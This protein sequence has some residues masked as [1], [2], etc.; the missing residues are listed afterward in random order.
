MKECYEEYA[1]DEIAE[2]DPAK[3]RTLLDRHDVFF[4]YKGLIAFWHDAAGFILKSAKAAK[5]GKEIFGQ[6][7]EILEIFARMTAFL[8]EADAF[9]SGANADPQDCF[10]MIG[11]TTADIMRDFASLLGDASEALQ[12]RIVSI[13]M[14]LSMSQRDFPGEDQFVPLVQILLTQKLPH[15]RAVAHIEHALHPGLFLALAD[16]LLLG[17]APQQ[18]GDGV[19]QDGFARAGFAGEHVQPAGKFHLHFIHQR[20][21]ADGQ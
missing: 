7:R 17:A 16:Q 5:L 3:L 11:E 20:D 12:M 9:R 18:Q 8:K 19:H 15:R 4:R 2:P 21:V 14:K 1:G 10:S 6:F 13:M